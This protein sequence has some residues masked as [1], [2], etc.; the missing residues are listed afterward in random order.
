MTRPGAREGGAFECAPRG[1]IALLHCH[2]YA[3][4]F[5][6]HVPDSGDEVAD[7]LGTEPPTDKFDFADEA[8]DAR[9]LDVADRSGDCR[10]PRRLVREMVGL[11]EADGVP[12][13]V[14]DES[15]RGVNS[16]WQRTVLARDRY[17]VVRTGPPLLD[18]GRAKP[19]REQAKISTPKGREG[20]P[21][22]YELPRT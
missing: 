19:S 22:A 2:D 10:S 17:E 21:P 4:R 13:D 18:V 9:R 16:V 14:A 15:P 3:G 5:A 6:V 1:G 12:V 11:D 8:V 7:H 20:G